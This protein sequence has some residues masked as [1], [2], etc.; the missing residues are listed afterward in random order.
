MQE[1]RARPD[2]AGKRPVEMSKAAGE[3]WRSLTQEEKDVSLPLPSYL[4]L[5]AINIVI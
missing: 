3:V 2:Q 5:P 4:S 1:F